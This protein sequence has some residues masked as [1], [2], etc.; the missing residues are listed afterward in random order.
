MPLILANTLA[1]ALM[2]GTY[3]TCSPSHLRAQ[4]IDHVS[5]RIKTVQDLLGRSIAC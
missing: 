2:M 5:D 3:T 4:A 1:I